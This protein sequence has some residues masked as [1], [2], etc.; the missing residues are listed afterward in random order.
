VVKENS[1][2]LIRLPMDLLKNL[3]LNWKWY[4]LISSFTQAFLV[5]PGNHLGSP[6]PLDKTE[7]HIFGVVLMN[8][9]SGKSSCYFLI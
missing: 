6:I 3:T 5:G 2:L 1:L 8:D 4:I 7:E 9:W